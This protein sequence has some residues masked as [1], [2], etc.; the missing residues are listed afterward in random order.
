MEQKMLISNH[1]RITLD[2]LMAIARISCTVDMSN[3]SHTIDEHN[4]LVDRF[5]NTNYHF[6]NNCP[7]CEM[8]SKIVGI[9]KKC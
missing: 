7:L 3:K 1:K 4:A 8:G 2:D 5:Q 9:E 6:E